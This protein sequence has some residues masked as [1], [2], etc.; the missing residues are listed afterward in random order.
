MHSKKET[1]AVTNLKQLTTQLGLTGAK[2]IKVYFKSG[3]V[4]ASCR[5]F[6]RTFGSSGA[7]LNETFI[8]LITKIDDYA[9]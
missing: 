2:F 5:Q 3:K 1:T 6:G 8:N 9:H 7:E 4:T